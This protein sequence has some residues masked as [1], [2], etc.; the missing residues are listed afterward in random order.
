MA[1]LQP[2][3][4][5]VMAWN[6]ARVGADEWDGPGEGALW[7]L[8]RLSAA[9][10]RDGLLRARRASVLHRLGRDD[11]ARKALQEARDLGGMTLISDWCR[12]R[13]ASYDRSGRPGD[14]LW[15]REWLAGRGP[16]RPG[17]WAGAAGSRAQTGR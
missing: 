2:D 10:P 7:H 15:W 17:A 11:E 4:E 1:D 12:A 5:R 8:D 9:R 14:A 6:D 16:G 3:A 13:A